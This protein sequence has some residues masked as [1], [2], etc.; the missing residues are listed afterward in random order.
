[1]IIVNDTK[2]TNT[3]IYN[4]PFWM[5]MNIHICVCEYRY[6]AFL[7]EYRC[8]QMILTIE[9]GKI[10][11]KSEGCICV[12][13]PP[14]VKPI[15]SQMFYLFLFYTQSHKYIFLKGSNFCVGFL[16]PFRTSDIQSYKID[17]YMPAYSH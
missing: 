9:G 8:L 13:F 11:W 2:Q 1:M 16:S 15:L 14:T 4:I 3:H 7:Y 10:Y 6:I 5:F 12:F 17:V